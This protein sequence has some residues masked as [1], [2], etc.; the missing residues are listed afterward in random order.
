MKACHQMPCELEVQHRCEDG[1]R[2]LLATLR[3]DRDSN[4]REV[5][6]LQVFLLII[7]IHLTKNRSPTMYRNGITH[8]RWFDLC[9][10]WC[11]YLSLKGSSIFF[12]S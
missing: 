4:P 2:G 7:C 6:A 8:R 1:R 5:G 10:C 3:A 9:L 12:P 11:N